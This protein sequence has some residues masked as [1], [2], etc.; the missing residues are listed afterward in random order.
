VSDP[1]PRAPRYRTHKTAH[2]VLDGGANLIRCTLR[3]L[4]DGGA[5]LE[6]AEEKFIP[7][8]FDLL[9]ELDEMV[10][11]IAGVWQPRKKMVV[12]SCATAWKDGRRIGAKFA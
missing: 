3:D 1:P 12:R 7:R 9:F 6:I 10:Q 11:G 4:S 8:M 5:S 2:I